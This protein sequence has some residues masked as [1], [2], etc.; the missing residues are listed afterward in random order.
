MKH[1]GDAGMNAATIDLINGPMSRR[2]RRLGAPR[3]RGVVTLVL[4]LFSSIWFGV[5]LLVLLFVYCSIGSAVPAV[6]E[7][8]GL[9]LTEFE[10]FHWWPFNVLILLLA[11]TLVTVTIRRIPLRVVNAG[12][13]MIH[14]GIVIMLA[15]SYYYFGTKVEGDAPVIRRHVRIEL[16]GLA[17]PQKLP[18]LPGGAA[19]LAA[20]Q[21]V[22]GFEIQ[23]TNSNWP[24]L[25]ED[26]KGK[27]AYAVNVLVTPPSGEQFIRQLLA[28]YPQYTE[29][30]LPGKGRAVKTTGKKLADE[31]LR[32]SLELEPQ[33]TFH[34]MKSWA[35]FIRKVGEREWTERPMPGMP[36]Y[37]D[38]IGSRDQV[39]FDPHFPVDIRPMDLNVPPG[40]APDALSEMSV[41]V[42]GFLRYAQMQ[43]RWR[44]GGP[45][46]NPVLRIT[47][48]SAHADEQAY[49][50]V[51]LDPVRRKVESGAVQF[52]WLNSA[53]EAESL[54]KQ[55][56]ATL[57]VAVPDADVAFDLPLTQE[58][59]VGREGSFTPIEKSA[60]SY[61]VLHVMDDLAMP[62]GRRPISVAMVEIQTP[63]A[64]FTR[65][66]A[67]EAEATRDIHGDADPHNPMARKAEQVDRR[68]Q[69][70]YHPRTAPVTFAAYPG[71]LYLAVN[72]PQT[73]ML[74]RE[75]KV[76]ESVEVIP[77]LSLRVDTL[78][79]NGVLEEKPFVVPPRSRDRGVEENLSMI[80]LEVG[81]G[82]TV[83]TRWLRFNQYALPSEAYAYAGRLT[84][85]PERFRLNDGTQVEVLF[86]RRRVR[87]RHPVAMEDFHLDT[88]VGGYT[89][90]TSTIR[91]Y[92]S[93]LR[94]LKDN[95]WTDPRPTAVNHPTEFG[96]Y[97]FFQAMW[98]RPTPENPNG[99][100]NYTGLGVGN[101]K[102]VYVQLA[103]CCLAVAGMLFAFYVKPLIKRRRKD[104]A[105][106]KLSAAERDREPALQSAR[107]IGESP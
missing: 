39:F 8:P 33:E 46:L 75:V 31:N 5:V 22:W 106:A 48:Q 100:M 43:Q 1:H 104:L 105:A 27:E 87:F 12:V 83:Q 28:G 9:E 95:Q 41:H 70:T 81:S 30:I 65:M 23:S 16:P 68:I 24:I 10:W 63:E 53:A 36:R 54:S 45:A 93:R 79:Q 4:D 17:E 29:D 37:H 78:L 102:G 85:V 11:I 61:R 62:G 21:G 84:Y 3:R 86:S 26:D 77:G 76:G 19:R 90:S 50:L 66:V 38:R 13:W 6:R 72:T 99:G 40:D 69:M 64:R 59:V 34:V 51:A 14:T 94:F 55:S 73:R 44:D 107:L 67:D 42:T 57:R 35:L 32:L 89:G 47:A 52:L 49:E 91:N 80:R 92:V 74:G 25:S 7:L 58:T 2:W 82:S 96:G 88:H 60:F 98:D 71:G 20:G 97:W 101:R 56:Q 103:G 18:A 15:G